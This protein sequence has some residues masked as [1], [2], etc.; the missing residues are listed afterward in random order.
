[1]PQVHKR[2]GLEGKEGNM[3]HR[4]SWRLAVEKDE[5]QE[6]GA[7][8]RTEDPI[9]TSPPAWMHNQRRGRRPA[10]TPATLEEKHGL[11]RCVPLKG[12]N[13]GKGD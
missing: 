7:T 12:E 5:D 11:C 8:S 3:W 4:G 9:K 1:M 13:G 2:N 6:D 10:P